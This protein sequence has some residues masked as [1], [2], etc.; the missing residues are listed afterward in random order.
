VRPAA[1]IPESRHCAGLMASRQAQSPPPQ[2]LHEGVRPPRWGF[3]SGLSSELG[4]GQQRL[5]R[6]FSR[7]PFCAGRRSRIANAFGFG[8]KDCLSSDAKSASALTSGFASRRLKADSAA[9]VGNSNKF[10]E[11]PTTRTNAV[12]DANGSSRR[13]FRSCLARRLRRSAGLEDGDGAR[14]HGEMSRRCR[15]RRSLHPETARS[16][17]G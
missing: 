9:E 4:G 11:I 17:L 3:L 7:G 15:R 8:E 16:K 5:R 12:E 6:E 1:P 13:L 14:S 10:P 2:F